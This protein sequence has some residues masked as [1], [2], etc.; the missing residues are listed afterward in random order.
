MR[1]GYKALQYPVFCCCLFVFLSVLVNSTA[2]VFTSLPTSKNL[3][4][5]FTFPIL[6]QYVIKEDKGINTSCITEEFNNAAL[7]GNCLEARLSSCEVSL[8]VTPLRV[9]PSCLFGIKIVPY[10]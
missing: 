3:F 7:R 4:F 6:S 5:L 9:L 8:V 10:S 2:G 1:R